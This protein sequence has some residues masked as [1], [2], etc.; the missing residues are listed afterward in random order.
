MNWV[1]LRSLTKFLS[2]LLTT[3]CR[4]NDAFTMKSLFMRCCKPHASEDFLA[5]YEVFVTLPV[6][7]LKKNSRTEL[8]VVLAETRLF[9][10]LPS[11]RRLGGRKTVM[12]SNGGYTASPDDE[13]FG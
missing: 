13:G 2:K 6:F 4:G 10:L 3:T 8:T 11:S 12:M 9:R 7:R 1:S 5:A